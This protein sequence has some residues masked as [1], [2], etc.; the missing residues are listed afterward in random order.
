M[1]RPN[2]AAARCVTRYLAKGIV[3]RAVPILQRSSE[4]TRSPAG[5]TTGGTGAAGKCNRAYCRQRFAGEAMLHPPPRGKRPRHHL[6]RVVV[7]PRIGRFFRQATLHW[8]P[9]TTYVL[10][11]PST[12][13]AENKLS[14][15][16]SSE[17]LRI[18]FRGRLI[19]VAG[20]FVCSVLHWLCLS[21][22]CA[23]GRS[24]SLSRW[25]TQSVA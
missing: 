11:T 15:V 24:L 4:P 17:G 10:G 2:G 12:A 25:N 18:S 8:R 21:Q 22:P 3:S 14:D 19:S 20:Q 9:H 23:R 1:R 6:H 13:S 7:Q 16:A 5:S